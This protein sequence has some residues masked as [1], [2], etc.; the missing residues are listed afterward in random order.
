MAEDDGALVPSLRPG[1]EM[2]TTMARH[3]G[4]GDGSVY[5][6]A[7]KGDWCAQLTLPTG[8][9][10]TVGYGRTK[11]EAQIKLREAQLLLQQGKLPM[12]L[13]CLWRIDDPANSGGLLGS[14][15]REPDD[16]FADRRRWIEDGRW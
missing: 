15:W 9:R 14:I 13:T 7:A 11:R 5:E 2:G 8:K 1:N 12:L 10:K 4:H 6:R 16:D 3:R